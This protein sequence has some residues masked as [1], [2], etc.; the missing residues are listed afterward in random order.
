M[1]GRGGPGNQAEGPADGPRQDRGPW[2]GLRAALHRFRF[3]IFSEATLAA[4][5]VLA[6]RYGVGWAGSGIAAAILALPIAWFAVL[7]ARGSRGWR[8]PR[9]GLRSAM[10]IVLAS[11]VFFALARMFGSSLAWLCVLSVPP[12]LLL[13]IVAHWPQVGSMRDALLRVEAIAARAGLPLGPASEAFATL[14]EPRYARR[15]ERL[16]ARLSEGRSLPDAMR[17]EPGLLPPEAG[18]VA[19]AT[20]GSDRL[21]PGLMLVSE[22]R[23]ARSRDLPSAASTIGYP[24]AVIAAVGL[25]LTFI[26]GSLRSRL[27]GIFNDLERNLGPNRFQRP[28]PSEVWAGDWLTTFERLVGS[29]FEGID[30]LMIWVGWSVEAGPLM[31]VVGLLGTAAA[32][33]WAVHRIGP[34][35]G[36]L[37]DHRPR[38]PRRDG[39]SRRDE[40]KLDGRTA[41]TG[42]RAMAEGSEAGRPL[43]E[44]LE[45]LAVGPELG[46]RGRRRSARARHLML[47][48]EAWSEALRRT[49]FVRAADAAVLGA[50]ARASN[51]S[52]ALRDRADSIDRRRTYRLK[53]AAA[54]LQ[55]MA[56]IAA[57]VLV[58]S[59]A[60]EVYGSLAHAIVL[61]S[62]LPG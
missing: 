51:L 45:G 19:R 53:A 58:L 29:I 41:S 1:T 10:L 49:G 44:V 33:Y 60:L 13:I 27:R 18:A 7:A 11:A 8:A 52:W 38:G 30:S 14:C 28:A 40:S 48:G 12:I 43:P 4:F 47:S 35:L 15:V 6:S 24:V 3:L 16:A 9:L 36:R 56:I 25:G 37:A 55:P 5:E 20:W 22:A 57:G 59:A 21:G 39:G 46:A 17:T 42:L 54:I 34:Q 61:M 31:L 2:D 26:H 32:I 62:E 50:A 23:S